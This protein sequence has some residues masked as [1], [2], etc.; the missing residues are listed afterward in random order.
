MERGQG[1][2]GPVGSTPGSGSMVTEL[3]SFTLD[4]HATLVDAVDHLLNRGAVLVGE[5]KLS[6][7]GVDLVYLGVN[8][9]VSSVETLRQEHGPTSGPVLSTHTSVEA[10]GELRDLAGRSPASGVAGDPG[11][12]QAA[13]PTAPAIPAGAPL[14]LP[15]RSPAGAS[16]EDRS[17]DREHET[18]RDL[19]RLVLTLIELL[20]QIL[21]RQAVRRMEGGG[22]SDAQIEAMGLALLEL[23]EK[24]AEFREMFHLEDADLNVDL[25]PLGTLL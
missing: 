13:P 17:A 15:P 16:R 9:L 4:R 22:L 18:G 12:G 7:A 8:L 10:P 1:H 21:E 11:A 23:E 20:R 3:P 14:E 24:M 2:A 25:G 6:L 19:A 5:A